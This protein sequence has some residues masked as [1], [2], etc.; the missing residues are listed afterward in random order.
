[1]PQPA[2]LCLPDPLIK[3][4]ATKM[5]FLEKRLNKRAMITLMELVYL[6][7][8]VVIIIVLFAFSGSMAKTL[9]GKEDE[10]MRNFDVLALKVQN[11]LKSSDRFAADKSF[12]M[13]LGDDYII[14]GYNRVSEANV[15]DC[16]AEAATKPAECGRDSSCLCLHKKKSGFLG[17]VGTK[18]DFDNS[19]SGNTPLRCVNFNNL[20]YIFT[21]KYDYYP[22]DNQVPQEVQKNLIGGM[23][24]VGL[25]EDYPDSYAYFFLY[26]KCGSEAGSFGKQNLYVEK[27]TQEGGNRILIAYPDKNME[28]HYDDMRK[29]YGQKTAKEYNEIIDLYAQEAR[30]ADAL[31]MFL[32]FRSRFPYYNLSKGTYTELSAY[33]V[34]NME[35]L[36]YDTLQTAVIVHEDFIKFYPKD[37][38][39][40]QFMYYIGGFYFQQPDY[41]NAKAAYQKMISI[42]SQSPLVPT[43]K[44]KVD[45]LSILIMIAREGD[46]QTALQ[47]Y[48]DKTTS[49][50]YYISAEAHYK[51]GTIYLASQLPGSLIE[52]VDE[53]Y[54]LNELNTV[55][56][57]YPESPYAA[58]ASYELGMFYERKEDWEHTCYSFGAVS[59]FLDVSSTT[60]PG[61]RLRDKAIEKLK[62]YKSECLADEL[63]TVDSSVGVEFS[64]TDCPYGPE[65]MDNLV[66]E[67]LALMQDLE[68]SLDTKLCVH[69]GCATAGHT[70][71]SY[72]YKCMAIDFHLLNNRSYFEQIGEMEN[73]LEALNRQNDV[74]LG[75]YP[76]WNNKGFH[77]DNRG[78]PARWG[79]LNGAEVSYQEA[80]NYAETALG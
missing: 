40:P 20:D 52:T 38:N 47:N 57:S 23:L 46:F 3:S 13:Y 10:N 49:D 48:Q 71:N 14:V 34:E 18:D 69:E 68:A 2:E 66:P 24:D 9:F 56:E 50:D 74:G 33:C 41:E 44:D 42:Y 72:H 12:P 16:G 39:V 19:Q 11:L 60:F 31:S 43:A 79:W 51:L 28:K 27:F 80:K 21:I 76:Q 67:M 64:T 61:E 77:I 26:G 5:F 15:D 17:I 35:F 59:K 30:F 6:I 70:T 25:T 65:K 53:A 36:D 73:A 22:A 45:Q 37:R 78:W 63:D 1:M 4:V 54:V 62:R 75:I 55:V 32:E 29:K 8:G 7:L 58:D